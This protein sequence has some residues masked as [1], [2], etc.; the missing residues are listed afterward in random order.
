MTH[1]QVVA[2][3]SLQYIGID[4]IHVNIGDTIEKGNVLG[5]VILGESL[6]IRMK[7]IKNGR[8]IYPKHWTSFND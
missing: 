5:T 7:V 4:S 2:G 8:I 1:N 3:S 6:V